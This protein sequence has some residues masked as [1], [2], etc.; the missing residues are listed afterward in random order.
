M[1]KGLLKKVIIYYRKH[2]K[3]EEKKPK[4]NEPEKKNQLQSRRLSFLVSL[5]GFDSQHTLTS[6]LLFLVF[7][8]P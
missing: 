2:I 5:Q 7:K 4:T 1:C 3:G 8:N 6:D